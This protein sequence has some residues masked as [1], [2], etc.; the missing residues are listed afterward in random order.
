MERDFFYVCKFQ[1][2]NIKGY[3]KNIQG[4]K[5]ESYQNMCK[6]IKKDMNLKNRISILLFS[7][8]KPLSKIIFKLFAR[9]P[10]NTKTCEEKLHQYNK[11]L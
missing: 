10:R 1:T 7:E 8:A 9:F 11:K 4:F 2:G 3:I 5:L 6:G